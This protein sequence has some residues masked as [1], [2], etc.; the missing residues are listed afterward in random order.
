[1]CQCVWRVLDTCHA[2]EVTRVAQQV[3]SLDN[4]QSRWRCNTPRWHLVAPAARGARLQWGRYIAWHVAVISPVICAVILPV[5]W[6]QAAVCP[7]YTCEVVQIR[8]AHAMHCKQAEE[9]PRPLQMRAI[10]EE[11][12]TTKHKSTRQNESQPAAR[13]GWY[14]ATERCAVEIKT[15][16]ACT[17]STPACASQRHGRAAS[18]APHGLRMVQQRQHA[19]H[20]TSVA[21]HEHA[22]AC[23]SM[24]IGRASPS[25]NEK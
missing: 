5:T 1:M 17:C 16:A 4:T 18:F 6:R 14:R 7:R 13:R 3:P 2:C 19:R 24:H 12:G 8:G 25:A 20:G 23:A 10:N 15:H 21:A 11:R 22:L 9:R